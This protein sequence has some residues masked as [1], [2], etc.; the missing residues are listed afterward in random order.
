M[1]VFPTRNEAMTKW[2]LKV[3]CLCYG[4]TYVPLPQHHICLLKGLCAASGCCV[5]IGYYVFASIYDKCY[6]PNLTKQ[7]YLD[8]AS[9]M[10]SY[11]TYIVVNRCIHIILPIVIYAIWYSHI[12]M[13][14][15]ILAFLFHRSWSMVN[16]N[17]TSIYMNGS[18][19]Y[20]IKCLPA[21][22]WTVVYIGE[23]LVLVISTIIALAIQM[24]KN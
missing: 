7:F 13:A 14:S 20:K 22:G 24:P 6:Q 2:W 11:S 19:I 8:N 3:T 4:L 18:P 9:T 15:S 10:M 12:T 5:A 17:F 21:W 1:Q 23:F 16:S